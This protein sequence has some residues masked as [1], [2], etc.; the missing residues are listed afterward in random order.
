MGL[1]DDLFDGLIS[2]LGEADFE[3]V[4]DDLEDDEVMHCVGVKSAE[5][6]F[7]GTKL[8]SN[9]PTQIYCDGPIGNIDI[10]FNHD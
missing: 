2:G 9:P 5:V 6:Y 1:F 7:G 8:P 10:N 4:D 3:T